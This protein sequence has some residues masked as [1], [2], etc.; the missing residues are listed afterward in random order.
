MEICKKN[1]CFSIKYVMVTL[2]YVH[3][4]T[5]EKHYYCYNLIL[6]TKHVVRNSIK[7]L[8]RI[9]PNLWTPTKP[10]ANHRGT[11]L[12]FQGHRLKVHQTLR[13]THLI[14]QGHR[15]K[16]HQTI[17][18]YIL[19]PFHNTHC[20]FYCK[21]LH[22]TYYTSFLNNKLFLSLSSHMDPF[23]FFLLSTSSFS[24]NYLGIRELKSVT[25]NMKQRKY[26][27]NHYTHKL[28]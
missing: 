6:L 18:I 12:I 24:K 28:K 16:V 4:L 22:I 3:K 17:R 1:I 2:K 11:H 8:K 14:F 19:P 23:F 25:S 15:L 26:K 10:Q 27:L 5:L 20:T 21:K 13:G 7:K 9:L